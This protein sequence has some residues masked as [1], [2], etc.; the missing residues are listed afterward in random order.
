M[1]VYLEDGQPTRTEPVNLA[2]DPAELVR[3]WL[4]A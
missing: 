1:A 2:G 4:A 3:A